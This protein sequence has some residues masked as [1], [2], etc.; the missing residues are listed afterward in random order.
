MVKFWTIQLT[1]SVIDVALRIKNC[2]SPDHFH[3]L[4]D[5]IDAEVALFTSVDIAVEHLMQQIPHLKL[6]QT[7]AVWSEKPILIRTDVQAAI[8]PYR[9][10][11][12]LLQGKHPCV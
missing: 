10:Y 3:A 4:I 2:I 6:S 7:L 5:A 8:A 12:W 9:R 11:T 1:R